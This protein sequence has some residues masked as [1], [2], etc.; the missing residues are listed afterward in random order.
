MSASAST[1]ISN[2]IFFVSRL[3]ISPIY[4]S[5]DLITVKGSLTSRVTLTSSAAAPPMLL[6]CMDRLTVVP[7][8][9]LS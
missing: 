5:E 6:T 9:M 8:A 3:F 1:M 4:F 7:G 2:S